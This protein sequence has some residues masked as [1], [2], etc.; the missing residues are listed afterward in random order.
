MPGH[1]ELLCSLFHFF[2]EIDKERMSAA[3]RASYARY[4]DACRKQEATWDANG[5]PWLTIEE[6]AGRPSAFRT[7]RLTLDGSGESMTADTRIASRRLLGELTEPRLGTLH[8]HTQP[9]AW[10]HFLSITPSPSPSSP[11]DATG[12]SCAAPGWYTQMPKKAVT[13][14]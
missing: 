13:T 4:L 5:L 3:E 11:S 9:N 10:Y 7:E 12:H 1:P 6:L 8:L 2:G 14:I